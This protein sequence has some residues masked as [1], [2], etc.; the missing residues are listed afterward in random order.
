MK[1]FLTII[2]ITFCFATLIGCKNDNA[3]ASSSE[4]KIVKLVEK[5]K[6]KQEVVVEEQKKKEEIKKKD[7]SKIKKAKAIKATEEKKSLFSEVGCCSKEIQKTIDGCCCQEVLTKYKVL[8]ANNKT[9]NIKK[10]KA[11][12]PIFN[13]CKRLLY[14]EFDCVDYP[15][16]CQPK[17]ETKKEIDESL[18]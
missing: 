2:I 3:V 17:N 8:R 14:K 11:T 7:N 10:M 12:D 16:S 13:D 18:I 1:E 5:E 15:E 6:L 9:E 4:D